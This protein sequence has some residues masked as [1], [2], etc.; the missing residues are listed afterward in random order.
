M[1]G[2][3]PV[4]GMPRLFRTAKISRQLHSHSPG[5]QLSQ[6]VQPSHRLCRRSQCFR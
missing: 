3:G 2:W 6:E 1:F 5:I 4:M